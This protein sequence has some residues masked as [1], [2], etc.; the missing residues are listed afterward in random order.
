MDGRVQTRVATTARG[1]RFVPVLIVLLLLLTPLLGLTL[2]SWFDW[3][4]GFK[5]V[6][7]LGWL[8][9]AFLLYSGILGLRRLGRV[10]RTTAEVGMAVDGEFLICL[11][12]HGEIRRIRLDNIAEVQIRKEGTG[13]LLYQDR[14]LA[15]V[16]AKPEWTDYRGQI[17]TSVPKVMYG[18]HKCHYLTT[19]SY[20][21]SI[22]QIASAILLA[23]EAARGDRVPF[24]LVHG[25]DKTP[26]LAR[27]AQANDALPASE[28][29]TLDDQIA[30]AVID[31]V[32]CGYD[33]RSIPLSGRCPECGV[34]VR[35]SLAG[36]ALSNTDR[37]W[38]T[39]LA[40]GGAFLTLACGLGVVSAMSFRDFLNSRIT[41]ITQSDIG[42]AIT[43]ISIL[44]GL[45]CL[46]IGAWLITR[47]EPVIRGRLLDLPSRR[48]VRL[49]LLAPI[50]ILF[51]T[52]FNIIAIPGGMMLNV[53]WAHLFL[54][55]C[56]WYT[57]HLLLR[58]GK[59]GW[60]AVT[61]LVALECFFAGSAQSFVV[62]S[63]FISRRF[64]TSTMS[65]AP[66][67]STQLA[68]GTGVATASESGDLNDEET[69]Q[70]DSNVE[71]GVDS[72]EIENVEENDEQNG[73][74]PFYASPTSSPSPTNS[75]HQPH[76]LPSVA[77]WIFVPT[78]LLAMLTLLATTTWLAKASRANRK[79]ARKT[80]PD[81]IEQE[82]PK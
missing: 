64:T 32:E 17:E 20:E 21:E 62:G 25:D 80:T 76:V 46:M 79:F 3:S 24:V 51:L 45:L 55:F 23:V 7:I 30:A 82:F 66:V 70:D 77:L 29:K 6:T 12:R 2:I 54:G 37:M 65:Y 35:R 68:A 36:R 39:W 57:R 78:P 63:M 15:L 49:M 53:A 9:R 19:P 34:P 28:L 27:T 26:L 8:F 73:A 14:G 42:I 18:R 5:K 44:G 41:G 43:A 60:A 59:H 38:V 81:S 40:V 48:I 13:R 56:V 22:E 16:L 50:V 47:P 1:S 10:L 75:S 72:N 33:L 74:N 31:C 67:P 11:G 52:A 69:F 71:H 4:T 58:L 61:V